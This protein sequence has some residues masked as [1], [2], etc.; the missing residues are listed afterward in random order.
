MILI[1]HPRSGSEFFIRSTPYPYSGLELLNENHTDTIKKQEGLSFGAR[2]QILKSSTECWQKIHAVHLRQLCEKQMLAPKIMA[3]LRERDDLYLLQRR[4]MRKSI[5]SE[6][7]ALSNNQNYHGDP[8]L[9]TEKRSLP[10]SI[11]MNL[12][13]AHY[14][15]TKWIENVF[16]YRE[17]FVFEDLLNGAAPSTLQWNPALSTTV[18]RDSWKLNLVPNIE[19]VSEWCDTLR[20]PGSLE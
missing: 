15:D 4:D 1:S 7:I 10:F 5:V 13:Q 2:F 14:I 11:F 18:Q 3:H 12:V 19:Q 8:K 17:S 16:D 20:I 6:W 9:L